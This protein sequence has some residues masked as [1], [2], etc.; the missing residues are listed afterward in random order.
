VKR[1]I[2]Y[3]V[4][5]IVATL[6]VG[7]ISDQRLVRY[8]DRESVIVFAL[9]VGVVSAY[10]K[11]VLKVLT[12]PLTCLTFGLFA[13]VLNA[14]LWGLAARIAPG[15]EATVWGAIVGSAITSIAAGIAFSILDEN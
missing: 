8:E 1:L 15:I 2:A 11:P 14:V 5:A 3:L 13:L 4:G 12:L 6:V 7:S 10:I 9:I